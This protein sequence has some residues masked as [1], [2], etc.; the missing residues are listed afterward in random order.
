MA[1]KVTSSPKKASYAGIIYYFIQD[2]KLPKTLHI[3]WEYLLEFLDMQSLQ[4]FNI[5]KDVSPSLL[6][7]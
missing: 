6:L 4:S 3:Y 1:V 7:Q 5:R 2:A